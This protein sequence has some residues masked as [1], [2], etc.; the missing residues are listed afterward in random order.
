MGSQAPRWAITNQ[1]LSQVDI[2]PHLAVG[3][4][5]FVVGRARVPTMV[6]IV[7]RVGIA[8]KMGAGL[9][10]A[11][12]WIVEAD[13]LV[14]GHAQLT[15][16]DLAG[17]TVFAGESSDRLGHQGFHS[18]HIAYMVSI[19]VRSLSGLVN[20]FHCSSIRLSVLTLTIDTPRAPITRRR[21]LRSWFS[22]I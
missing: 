4:L 16:V 6:G 5:L 12:N 2:F 10:S 3:E 21:S 19:V 13:R 22:R 14:L 11:P 20:R 8:T 1:S 15:G 7:Y 9:T 18:R 17:A